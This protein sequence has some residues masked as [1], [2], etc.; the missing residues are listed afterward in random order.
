MGTGRGGFLPRIFLHFFDRYHQRLARHSFRYPARLVEEEQRL[1]FR[2]AFLLSDELFLSSSAYFENLL[3]RRILKEHRLLC[4]AG[5]VFLTARDPTLIEHY[6]RK[7]DLHYGP[8]SPAELQAVYRHAPRV[9]V[10]YRSADIMTAHQIGND[11]FAALEEGNLV[12]SLGL[13]HD[14]VD[15]K[16]E[17]LWARIPEVLGPKAFV[18][19][20]VIRAFHDLGAES[21]SELTIMKVLDPGYTSSHA[22]PLGC[23]IVAELL[24]LQTPW[25][26]LTSQP[27]FSYRRVRNLAIKLDLLQLMKSADSNGLIRTR[28]SSSWRAIAPTF[29]A[30][31]EGNL[32]MQDAVAEVQYL[33]TPH[34]SRTTTT[35]LEPSV[36]QVGVVTALPQEW[37]A[38]VTALG[39]KEISSISGDPNRYASVTLP[40]HSVRRQSLEVIVTFLPRMGTN[41]AATVATNML[42][43]FP[44][45][46]DLIFS[47]I[48]CGCPRPNEPGKHVRLGD[49]VVSDL[50]G[51][52]QTDHQTIKDRKSENRSSMPVPSR[53][54]LNCVRILEAE[55]LRGENAWQEHLAELAS[56][57]VFRRPPPETDIL[58]DITGAP[59]PHPDEPDRQGAA[60][61]VFHGIIGSSNT[62]LR[63]ARVR[64]RLAGQFD[65]RAFEME[66]AGAAEAMWQFGKSYLVV[67]GI[68]DYGDRIKNDTWHGYAAAAAAAY[69]KA[70]L[71]RMDA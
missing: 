45:V 55:Q 59:I 60:P 69:T 14:R 3:A 22:L 35:E 71:L 31:E 16:F 37:L 33:L 63:N 51:I 24:Y 32:A 27:G 1:A 17:D 7:R 21:P 54:L 64:D 29:L 49:V 19:P 9:P 28:L 18:A 11:W 61:K 6:E 38:V 41:S 10:L 50:R 44:R 2:L 47:G 48:A 68:C 57:I 30:D 23:G 52:I 5:F 26:V 62:L 46:Q 36:T 56:N 65:L 43:S 8:G 58:L 67:R 53:K 40:P 42:R 4:E 34:K 15:R 12:K 13:R 70:V 20:H 25:H 39:A 66:G